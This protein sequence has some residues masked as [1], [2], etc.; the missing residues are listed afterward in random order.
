MTKRIR[1]PLPALLALVLLAGCGTRQEQ[2][3]AYNTRDLRVVDRLIAEVQGNLDRGYAFENVTVYRD[4][5]TTCGGER[6][7]EG[8][9]AKPPRPCVEEREYTEKRPKA[10]DLAAEA[11]KLEGLRQKRA[12]L[13]FA[14]KAVIAKC[15]ALHPE[16]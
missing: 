11:Q 4:Y 14:A 8:E 9:I 7:E 5:W 16:G 2:C 10:I 12:D 6:T 13:T 1:F 3:I 15:K